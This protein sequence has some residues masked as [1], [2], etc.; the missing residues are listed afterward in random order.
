MYRPASD[1]L[2]FIPYWVM[3]LSALI[4]WLAL[5]AWRHRRTLA[6]PHFSPPAESSDASTGT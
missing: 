3:L 2:L 6:T 5:F 4:V 1:W